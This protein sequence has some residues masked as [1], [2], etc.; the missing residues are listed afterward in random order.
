MSNTIKRSDV[1]R[2]MAQMGYATPEHGQVS[3]IA[4]KISS[5]NEEAM[6]VVYT[7]E[8]ARGGEGMELMPAREALATYP[9]NYSSAYIPGDQMTSKAMRL[10]QVGPRRWLLQYES[11]NDWKANAGDSKVTLIMEQEPQYVE[12]VPY[13][14]WAVD[15]IQTSARGLVAVDFTLEPSLQPIEDIL[16]KEEIAALIT[17]A[18]R[19]F[20]LG[21]N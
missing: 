14:C 7:D 6:L 11:K 18:N 9:D 2:M 5:E 17:M 8:Y 3:T 19:N 15:F 13:P 1:Y 20:G 16:T 4:P 10:L 12:A 21:R